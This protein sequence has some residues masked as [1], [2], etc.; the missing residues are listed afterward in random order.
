M[1]AQ[2]EVGAVT[3]VE[4]DVPHALAR[5]ARTLRKS[6]GSDRRDRRGEICAFM[7]S[8]LELVLRKH[9]PDKLRLLVAVAD[10]E[11]GK[12][13]FMAGYMGFRPKSPAAKGFEIA[14]IVQ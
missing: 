3:D 1:T 10:L 2:R 11:R 5:T 14:P 12:I 13:P 7:G 8:S 4:E 9:S 6:R